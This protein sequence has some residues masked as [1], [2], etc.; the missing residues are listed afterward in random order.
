MATDQWEIRL[1]LQSDNHVL[2]QVLK[3]LNKKCGFTNIDNTLGNTFHYLCP[4][5][6]VKSL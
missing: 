3:K 1:V 4:V 5:R 2:A 6:M